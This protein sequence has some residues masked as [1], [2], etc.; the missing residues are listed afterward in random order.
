MINYAIYC[1]IYKKLSFKI[2]VR[3]FLVYN[4]V[5]YTYEQYC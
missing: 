4:I 2:L 1:I 3:N 5:G